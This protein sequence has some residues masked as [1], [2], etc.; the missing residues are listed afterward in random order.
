MRK[1]AIYAR[2][3]SDLQNKRSCE[4]QDRLCRDFIARRDECAGYPIVPY[5]DAKASGA[6]MG[7]RTA[8]QRLMQDVE[9]NKIHSIISEGIDRLSRSQE[10]IARIYKLCRYHKVPIVTCMEGTISEIHVGLNGTM[11]AIQLDQIAQRTRRGQAGNIRQGKAAGGLPYGYKV[12][13]LNDDGQP[14]PG[15][16]QID[17]DEAKVVKRIY[18]AFCAGKTVTAITKDL[19][20]DGIPSP[21]GGRWTQSTINGHTGRG[22]GILQNVIYKGEIQ[23]NRNNFARHPSTGK[24][25]VRHNPEGDIVRHEN[26]DLVIIDKEQWEWAQKIRKSRTRAQRSE[27]KSY[28]KLPFKVFHSTCRAPMIRSGD[29][30]LICSHY[31]GKWI[32][33]ESRKMRI[34]AIMLAIYEAMLTDMHSI[35]QEWKREVHVMNKA[36]R[37]RRNRA[38]AQGKLAQ[39]SWSSPMLDGVGKKVL[40]RVIKDAADAPDVFLNKIVKSVSVVYDERKQICITKLIP[41]WDVLTQLTYTQK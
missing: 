30:Y 20:K 38:F 36:L 21:R 35:W 11:S 10:D 4:D 26:A 3:S 8:L 2:Y 7:K 32:C 24:R 19:N 28:T 29:A 22:N 37:Q 23:W 40:M 41:N 1:I 16:R 34:D 5:H 12:R 6:Y 33:N 9:D 18:D 14:E 25:H 27:R 15:L 17:P 13:H 39:V 31:K